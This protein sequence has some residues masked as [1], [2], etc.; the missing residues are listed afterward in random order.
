MSAS[1]PVIEVKPEWIVNP[2]DMGTK[3]KFWYYDPDQETKWLFKH[4]RSNTGEHWAEKIAAEVA[5]AAGIPHA[6]TELAL[7]ENIRGSATETFARGGRAL[8]HGNQLLKGI[9]EGYHLES[10]KR[11][12]QSHHTLD[13]IWKVADVF[14]A[15]PDGAKKAKR[16]IAS[17]L[18][19]DALIGNTDRHHENWGVLLKRQGDDWHG[20]VAPSFDHASSL[21]RELLDP[22]RARK[23]EANQVGD[24]AEKAHGAIYWSE[25][26]ARGP[27]PLELVRRGAHKYP[28]IFRPAGAKL[29]KINESVIRRIVDSIPLD[30]M[31]P[32]A[33]KFAVALM[34]YNLN[35]LQRTFP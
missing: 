1:Y 11:H 19:L 2:E 31:S 30:W 33:R 25:S 28:E 4:P 22:R 27:S 29:A 14:F 17:Y 12:R 6:K 8:C 35:T 3:K 10:E 20:M 16:F 9:V 26:D 15:E 18:V 34:C 7:H 21:G 32:S 13:N 5:S 24:Y 23:M